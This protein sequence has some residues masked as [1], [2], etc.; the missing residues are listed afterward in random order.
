MRS[1]K[2]SA[3]CLSLA[4]LF[5]MT[6]AQAGPKKNLTKSCANVAADMAEAQ[7][8]VTIEAPHLALSAAAT[9]ARSMQ[10]TDASPGLELLE[11]VAPAAPPERPDLVAQALGNFGQF[12]ERLYGGDNR[13]TLLPAPTDPIHLQSRIVLKLASLQGEFRIPRLLLQKM[14]DE[15]RRRELEVRAIEEQIAAIAE[16]M[17]DN[18]RPAYYLKVL[19]T[20]E[21]FGQSSRV[22]ASP[23]GF[24]G[25]LIKV[26]YKHSQDFLEVIRNSAMLDEAQAQTLT[27]LMRLVL[28]GKIDV[29]DPKIFAAVE[30]VLLSNLRSNA[31]S[32]LPA[33]HE[34]LRVVVEA[35]NIPQDAKR[36]WRVALERL[37]Y[38]E[39]QLETARKAYG[40][41]YYSASICYYILS[42]V[43]R[44]DGDNKLDTANILNRARITVLDNNPFVRSLAMAA[45]AD[46]R[47]YLHPTLDETFQV[48]LTSDSALR[49]FGMEKVDPILV[50][51]IDSGNRR[52]A[53]YLRA[54]KQARE[55]ELSVLRSFLSE[56]QWDKVQQRMTA[57]AKSTVQKAITSTIGKAVP[58]PLIEAIAEHLQ[59]KPE[60][61]GGTVEEVKLVAPPDDLPAY[62]NT[63]TVRIGWDD[64]AL[65]F[66][67]AAMEE[68]HPGGKGYVYLTQVLAVLDARAKVILQK[69]FDL[70]RKAATDRTPVPGVELAKLA[71]DIRDLM[72]AVA[73]IN[74][75]LDTCFLH[76][77]HSEAEADLLL[78]WHIS[79]NFPT[80]QRLVINNGIN[81]SLTGLRR[82][83]V[84][85]AVKSAFC[86]DLAKM[87]PER[88]WTRF[89]MQMIRRHK[90]K[91]AIAAVVIAAGGF[92]AYMWPSLFENFWHRPDANP[93]AVVAPVDP[94][95]T[96][97]AEPPKKDDDPP[98]A[99]DPVDATKDKDK[100]KE[101]KQ[102]NPPP[103]DDPPPVVNP[104]EGP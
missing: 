1:T 63:R 60:K 55:E 41:Q 7:L 70:Q 66:T 103:D 85:H 95:R 51:Q 8:A 49:R 12:L 10:P 26:I 50:R 94:G 67:T 43:A 73:Q 42:A 83:L 84:V 59:D 56:K 102:Q 19:S 38:L 9:S 80:V 100:G 45:L 96:P 34:T 58:A 79:E 39:G 37:K 32:F 25:P 99:V 76:N 86:G 92:A 74:H 91:A 89:P 3:F 98:P 31:D 21:E 33:T 77:K 2:V 93:P 23:H 22:M 11:S 104:P 81:P 4:L 87:T 6:S 48:R 90:V 5:L 13:P 35:A 57:V 97:A 24:F 68:G 40:S 101:N 52:Q 14:E 29:Q 17:G 64:K 82:R 69:D 30:D 16:Q 72:E 71:A 88:P 20:I 36:D 54:L 18:Y 78:A 15:S 61:P 27:V 53:E 46:R 65:D 62:L 75:A 28:S 44:P 47:S